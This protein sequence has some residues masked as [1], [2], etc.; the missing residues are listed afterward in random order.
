MNNALYVNNKFF[1]V[2]GSLPIPAEG[3]SELQLWKSCNAMVRGWLQSSMDK[4]IN[5]NVKHAKTARE[6]WEDLQERFGSESAP[7]AFELNRSIT[8][9]RQEKLSVFAYYTKLKCLWDDFDSISPIPKC[10]CSGCSCDVSKQLAMMR[11]K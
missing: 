10:K 5:N 9:T 6:V 11:E 2:D 8:L 1:F 4:E 7:R 3:S